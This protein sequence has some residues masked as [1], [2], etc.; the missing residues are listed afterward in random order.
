MHLNR[1]RKRRGNG[2]GA[3]KCAWRGQK[4]LL[5]WKSGAASVP[6]RSS[7][8]RRAVSTATTHLRPMEFDSRLVPHMQY[9]RLPS[10]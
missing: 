5:N 1:L 7:V 3:D 4:W 9:I 6:N 10:S 8:V 2:F